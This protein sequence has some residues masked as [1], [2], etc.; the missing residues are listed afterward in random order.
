MAS[1]LSGLLGALAVTF[2][3]ILLGYVLRHA[4]VSQ[5]ASRLARYAIH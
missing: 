3:V 1:A 2:G 5:I 4:K